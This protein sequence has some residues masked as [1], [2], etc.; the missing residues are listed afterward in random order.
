MVRLFCRDSSGT[1]TY[2]YTYMA[3]ACMDGGLLHSTLILKLPQPGDALLAPPLR[4]EGS[5]FFF[6]LSYG[7]VVSALA[8]LK[9]DSNQE[10][11]ISD[12]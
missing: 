11:Q 7:G 8:S 6:F 12:E 2:I 9:R 4:Q 3:S 10:E 5:V 1:N